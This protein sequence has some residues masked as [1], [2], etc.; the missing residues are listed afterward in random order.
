MA[1]VLALPAS[2]SSRTTKQ[3]FDQRSSF[4]QSTVRGL[5]HTIVCTV[6]ITGTAVHGR[7]LW[8]QVGSSVS[9][10]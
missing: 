9:T 4:A 1:G 2:V 6:T 5:T 8:V 7:R 3:V 10:E